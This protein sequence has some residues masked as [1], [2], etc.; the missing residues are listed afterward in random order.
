MIVLLV[1]LG[2]VAGAFLNLCADTLPVVGRLQRPTCAYCGQGRPA[3]AWSGTAAYLAR[4]HRCPSC[5]AP[6][7]VRHVL[8]ELG[9]VLLYVLT[10]LR[11]GMTIATLLHV[12]YGSVFLLVLVTDIEHRL[13]QHAVM[14]P[15]I[16]LAL[17]GAFLD[18]AFDSPRRALLG[19]VIGLL[20]TLVLYVAG[21]LFGWWMGRKRGRPLREAAFGFGDVTLTTFIGLVVGAP[22]VLFALLIGVLSAGLFSAGYLLVR[23]LLQRRYTLFTAIPYGPFLILGGATMLYWGPQVMAWYLTGQGAVR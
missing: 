19:A 12:A 4:R 16:L 20:A 17:L 1:L 22:E 3:V 15:A 11:S 23:G 14:L 13:I 10:W 5:A 6:L 18:P 21:A 8:V 9:T 7:P 2:M